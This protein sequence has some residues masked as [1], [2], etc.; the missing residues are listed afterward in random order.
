MIFQAGGV[1][2]LLAFYGIYFGKAMA[3]RRKGIRTDQ[4]ARGKK[5]G[6][7]FWTELLMK[8]A[9]YLIVCVESISVIRNFTSL[10]SCFRWMGLSVS[11]LGVTIF[12]ISVYTMRDS[13]R[14]G[15]PENDRTEF[16]T[17]GIYGWS[18]N[19]AFLGFDLTYIGLLFLFFNPVLLVCTCFA[20]LMLHLQ[21]LQEERFLETVFGR[22]YEIYKKRVRRYLGKT[23]NTGA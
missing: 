7:L 3:Q 14:A 4:I 9:T 22:E 19:P 12:G 20:M 10:P 11:F 2:V 21:I 8:V 15:I 1:F 18:R 16:V 13:W 6:A 23:R 5:R 17:T